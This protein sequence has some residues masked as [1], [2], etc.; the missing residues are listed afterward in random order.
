MVAVKEG[1][2][3]RKGAVRKV[4]APTMVAHRL[5]QLQVNQRG[6]LLSRMLKGH[7]KLAVG[8]KRKVKRVPRQR[9]IWL[10][11]AA[12]RVAANQRR[13]AARARI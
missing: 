7:L 4:G 6:K 11:T 2:F 13:L 9:M 3:Q 8:L 5:L 1:S 12:T 10:K